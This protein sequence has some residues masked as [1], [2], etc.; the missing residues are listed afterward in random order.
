MIVLPIGLI[1]LVKYLRP[2]LLDALALALLASGGIYLFSNQMVEWYPPQA[3][4]GPHQVIFE[5]EFACANHYLRRGFG[6]GEEPVLVDFTM[7]EKY[8][9]LCR[10]GTDVLDAGGVDTLQFV[11]FERPEPELAKVFTPP[12]GF[13][14]SRTEDV[15]MR[16]LDRVQF[17]HLNPIPKRRFK[18][19]TYV[20]PRGSTD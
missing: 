10:I 6:T 8:C 2:R 19:Y 16:W 3:F 7:F 5:N 15:R 13:S 18:V 4:D 12:P 17:R 20:R 14:L 1:L 9:K 11:G